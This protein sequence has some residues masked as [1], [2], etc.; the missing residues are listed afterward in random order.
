MEKYVA[1]LH[2]F[3]ASS[4]LKLYNFRTVQDRRIQSLVEMLPV[5]RALV[6]QKNELNDLNFK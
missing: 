5:K 3:S 4:T 6:I 2:I 1:Y